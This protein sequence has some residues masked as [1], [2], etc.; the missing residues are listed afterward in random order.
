MSITSD[1]LC[2]AA[3]RRPD[4]ALIGAGPVGLKLALDLA[5][6]GL[7]VLLIESGQQALSDAEIPDPARHAPMNLAV[8]RGLGGTS[9]L[10]GGRAVA[11]DPIDFAQRDWA[12]GADWPLA[13][14][15]VRP[16][17][18]TACRFLDCGPPVFTE[19]WPEPLPAADGLRLDELERW[20]AQP[21]M[22][23]VH[24]A[25]VG[26]HPHIAVA[27]DATVLKITVAED[28]IAAV[29]VAH[30]GERTTVNPRALI[31]AAGGVETARLLL[32]SRVDR[33]HLF[34]G[35]DGALGRFYMG[36]AFGSI[37]DIQFLRREDDARFNF[38]KDASGRYVRRRFTLD[39]AT[40]TRLK[41]L[42]MSAWPELPELY[43]PAHR[44]AILS[45]AYLALRMP[46][47]GPRLMAEAIRRRKL[48]DGP[49][50][51]GA[52][53]WN[54]LKGSPG[55]AWFAI[56][57]LRARGAK[58]RLPGFFVLNGAHRYAF[59]FHAEHAPSA[60]SRVTLADTRDALG[61]PRARID[62]RFG[63]VDA[64]S[65]LATHDAMA[66]RLQAAGIAR[67]EH[68]LPVND[69]AA[70][71]LAQASDGFHQVGTARMAV[72]PKRGVVDADAR[73]H[74]TA[75][76]FLAG[77]AIFPSSGQANP[78]LLAVALAARL[79]DHLKAALP[80]LPG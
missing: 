4:V 3:S 78:T 77:S 65:I 66:E 18:D 35:P 20:C 41:L 75:N 28:G 51:I 71:I 34:G 44:S 79:A 24:G 10:W 27:L 54:V 50:R 7:Q 47:I 32:A 25:R 30:N 9:L 31:V 36:H 49:A 72:D 57:F 16:W 37:A 22:A 17:Y 38:H 2:N 56:N 29:E 39:A 62:L 23:A 46:V 1:L 33:P 74:G 21:N 70:A 13:D 76:L 61:M 73:V 48:G 68:H 69:R 5:D 60:D 8:K 11:F 64:E 40:Q 52:H 58:V 80:D 12:P 59:H 43:D 42:N 15:D 26:A 67:I 55:A 45:L 14:T 19:T 53:L 6:A 63:A